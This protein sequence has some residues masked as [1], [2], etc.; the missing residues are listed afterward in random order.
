MT[1]RD[2]AEPEP[3]A[4]ARNGRIPRW[5]VGL[6]YPNGGQYF[7][8]IT[9]ERRA[10]LRIMRGV[11][12]H[13]LQAGVRHGQRMLEQAAGER[14][15]LVERGRVKAKLNPEESTEMRPAPQ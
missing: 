9:I 1:A 4:P 12:V 8:E 11:F 5:R 14:I 7:R 2:S 10:Q 15:E 3:D 13:E 6:N